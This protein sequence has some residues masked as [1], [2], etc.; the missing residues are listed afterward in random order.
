[1]AQIYVCDE[2]SE[3]FHGEA[4]MIQVSHS[5]AVRQF[6]TGCIIWSEL[7]TRVLT[8]PDSNG[9]VEIQVIKM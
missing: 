5:G 8:H 1:M 7:Y 6:H 9:R 3:P 4:E 2:C